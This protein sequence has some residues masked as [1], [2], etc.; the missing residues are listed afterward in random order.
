MKTQSFTVFLF[1]YKTTKAWYDYH[2]VILGV[3]EYVLLYLLFL[4]ILQ[5]FFSYYVKSYIHIKYNFFVL[6]K[7]KYLFLIF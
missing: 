1:I 3:A 5:I 4:M 2:I 6:S 7:H